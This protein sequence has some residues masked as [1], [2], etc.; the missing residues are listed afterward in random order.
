MLLFSNFHQQRREI[1]INL[2]HYSCKIHA[3]F[4]LLR[5]QT[6]KDHTNPKIKFRQIARTLIFYFFLK[7]FLLLDVM[8][9]FF[10]VFVILIKLHFELCQPL[11][12]FSVNIKVN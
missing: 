1:K 8:L 5:I 4:S 6:A 3:R 12:Q 11:E 9:I 2:I 10:C 7:T